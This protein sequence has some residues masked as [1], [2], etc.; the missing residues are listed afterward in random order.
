LN[1]DIRGGEHIGV[2]GRT[3]AGKSSILSALFRITEL[4]GG[5]IKID[6]VDIAT[7]GVQDLR[8]RLTIIPQD[9]TLFRGTIRSNPDPFNKHA[10]L[11]LWSALRKTHLVGEEQYNEALLEGHVKQS[12]QGLIQIDL[13]TVVE[14]EGH[15]FSLGQR[16]LI[17][18]AQPWCITHPSLSAMKPRRPL[19]LM[20]ISG[21]SRYWL[22]ISTIRR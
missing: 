3:G 6:N 2:V 9:P 16:Q 11:E 8:S 14:E 10:D 21:F 19:I 5:S 15:N 17:A 12:Q 20:Q 4:C 1:V 22:R 7:T 13:D 18:L